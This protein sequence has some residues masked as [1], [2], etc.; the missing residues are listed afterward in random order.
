MSNYGIPLD[1][2][3]LLS[4]VLEALLYGF[5]LLMFGGTIC[6]LWSKRSTHRVNH[7]MVTVACLLLLFSTV[8]IVIDIIRIMEGLILYRDTYPEGPVGFFSDVSQWTFVYKNYVYTAQTLLGDGVISVHRISCDAKRGLWWEPLSMDY[9][10]LRI[11]VYDEPTDNPYVL[12]S[13]SC[14]SKSASELHSPP[15][16]QFCWLTVSGPSTGEPRGCVV[17][18]NPTCGPFYTSLSM[19]A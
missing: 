12:A 19:L 4:A 16:Y 8:H 1:K 9:V 15:L 17:T 10:V 13:F 3:E 5:S 11:D 14:M 7:R 2:A 18:E 6:V